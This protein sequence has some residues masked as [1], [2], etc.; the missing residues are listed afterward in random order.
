M[1]SRG[2]GEAAGWIRCAV[3]QVSSRAE[4]AFEFPLAVV[5][6]KGVTVQSDKVGDAVTKRPKTPAS[7]DDLATKV[8]EHELIKSLNRCD[9]HQLWPRMSAGCG[10]RVVCQP[11]SVAA[12]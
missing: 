7:H 12:L 11:H 5:A 3:R 2:P 8:R 1:F 9:L 4:T 6:G 10:G